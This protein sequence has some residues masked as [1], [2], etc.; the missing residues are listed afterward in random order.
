[1]VA[2]SLAQFVLNYDFV[3]VKLQRDIVMS[4]SFHYTCFG[5]PKGREKKNWEN[6]R[7]R[8]IVSISCGSASDNNSSLSK[9]D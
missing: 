7:P 1:M 4:C 3:L 5:Y 2:H 6:E 9:K 8:I